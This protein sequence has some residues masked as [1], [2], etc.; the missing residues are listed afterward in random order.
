MPFKSGKNRYQLAI[1]SIDDMI[2]PEAE[3]RI[4]KVYIVF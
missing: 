4:I 2:D 1:Q 3:V